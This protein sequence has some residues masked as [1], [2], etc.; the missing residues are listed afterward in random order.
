MPNHLRKKKEK[1]KKSMSFESIVLSV[2]FFLVFFNVLWPDEIGDP[3]SNHNETVSVLL[4]INNFWERSESTPLS[5]KSMN[6]K[7]DL[8][9]QLV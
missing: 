8:V 6:N 7:A 5:R 4:H 9:R 3:S 1:E 2:V